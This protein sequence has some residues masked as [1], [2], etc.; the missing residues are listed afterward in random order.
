MG[1]PRTTRGAAFAIALAALVGTS[2]C[3]CGEPGSET[4]VPAGETAKTSIST[5]GATA[6]S[7]SDDGVSGEPAGNPTATDPAGDSAGQPATDGSE[8]TSQPNPESPAG[9]GSSSANPTES[10]EAPSMGDLPEG[11]TAES[12]ESAVK[13]YLGEH[14]PSQA[15]L[16]Q[17][18]IGEH[19]NGNSDMWASYVVRFPADRVVGLEVTYVRDGEIQVSEQRYLK[20]ANGLFY[21]VQTQRYATDLEVEGLDQSGV[22]PDGT[23]FSA[24]ADASR[25]SES[26]PGDATTGEID[27]VTGYL[28]TNPKPTK[29][30]RSQGDNG[31]EY[32][33]RLND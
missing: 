16:G 19:A 31:K 5:G 6:T 17:E 20:A 28:I 8:T 11:V 29:L 21:D 13:D 3:G 10:H 33:V 27:P 23:R 15:T 1:F 9:D 30:I 22:R 18:L 24:D 25:G 7:T 12:I 2:L 26:Q 14:Y 4:D 32:S